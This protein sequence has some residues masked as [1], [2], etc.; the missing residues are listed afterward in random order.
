MFITPLVK[1]VHKKTNAVLSFYT[2]SKY[3]DWREALGNK[4]TD[5][6]YYKVCL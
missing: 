5:E 6:Y 1:A 2:L 4:A 3:D